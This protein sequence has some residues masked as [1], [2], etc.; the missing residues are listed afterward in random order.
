MVGHAKDDTVGQT[1]ILALT[2]DKA[3]FDGFVVWSSQR[4][5]FFGRWIS[6]MDFHHLDGQKFPGLPAVRDLFLSP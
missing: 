5:F 6:R 1:C 4:F 2:V 3:A